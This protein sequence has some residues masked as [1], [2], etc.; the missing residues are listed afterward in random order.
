MSY[1]TSFYTL[2]GSCMAAYDALIE[3]MGGPFDIVSRARSVGIPAS[4]LIAR[5]WREKYNSEL[6]KDDEHWNDVDFPTRAHY[7]AFT[8][9][10]GHR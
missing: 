2:C 4:E 5:E 1:R 6:V 10:W 3:E 8:L 9:K 7:I